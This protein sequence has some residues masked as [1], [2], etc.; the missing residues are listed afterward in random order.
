MPFIMH[1]IGEL[2]EPIA[3]CP[4]FRYGARRPCRAS[5]IAAIMRS[6][7]IAIR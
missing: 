4:G 5:L 6:E 3:V 2:I 1:C 7:P